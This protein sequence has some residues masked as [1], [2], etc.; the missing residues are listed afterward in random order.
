MTHSAADTD[1][2]AK[3]LDSEGTPFA[4]YID[5]LKLPGNVAHSDYKRFQLS[6]PPCGCL[7]IIN[8]DSCSEPERTHSAALKPCRVSIPKDEVA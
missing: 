2:C 1:A 5:L 8:D 7:I 6:L 4:S 3:L